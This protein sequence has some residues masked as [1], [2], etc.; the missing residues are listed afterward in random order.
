MDRSR[1]LICRHFTTWWLRAVRWTWR[2]LGRADEAATGSLVE[3]SRTS[4]WAGGHPFCLRSSTRPLVAGSALEWMS[5]VEPRLRF[6]RG[7]M[8]EEL[9][10]LASRGVVIGAWIREEGA[11]TADHMLIFANPEELR[12]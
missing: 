7:V 1:R 8:F 2:V 4:G 10:R 6:E 5:R 3:A 9:G 12:R 11:V